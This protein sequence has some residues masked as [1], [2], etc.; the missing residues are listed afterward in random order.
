MDEY[1]NYCD[2]LRKTL[3][4]LKVS[5][6]DFA[7]VVGC[8]ESTIKGYIN[9]YPPEG[10]A[11]KR[12]DAALYKVSRFQNYV[13]IPSEEF[14]DIIENYL[15]HFKKYI[16]QKELAE[17]IGMSG[18]SRVS[19]LTSNSAKFS[20]EQ[21]YRI[22]NAFLDMCRKTADGDNFHEKDKKVAEGIIRLLNGEKPIIT[23][24]EPNEETSIVFDEDTLKKII[25]KLTEYPDEIQDVL[26]ENHL[27]FFDSAQF[28]YSED[29]RF[30]QAMSY[31]SIFRDDFD[32]DEKLWFIHDLENLAFKNKLF[33]YH[34]DAKSRKLFE[35]I[36][37]YRNMVK[38]AEKR[39]KS[40]PE[41]PPFSSARRSASDSSGRKR[42]SAD[43]EKFRK[44]FQTRRF[45][46]VFN[47]L[48]DCELKLPCQDAVKIILEEIEYRLAMTPVEWYTWMLI[49]GCTFMREETDAIDR[50]I[51]RITG[52]TD[53]YLDI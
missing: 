23:E 20:A 50:S 40:E 2:Y 4:E 1:F 3:K 8:S 43:D 26:I 15:E 11:R 14:S 10:E 37:H 36:N 41:T 17:R 48:L 32:S 19:K 18:Q 44:E 6:K 49:S 46:K 38:I 31:I 27:A 9:K 22:L 30:I 12:I 53:E 29:R 5:Q 39:A 16:T 51:L 24:K 7:K 21:Q 25:E 33:S 52:Q 42:I 35:M 47:Q 45:E 34:E 28:I 13:H